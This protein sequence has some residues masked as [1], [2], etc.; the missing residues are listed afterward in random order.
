MPARADPENMKKKAWVKPHTFP[1]EHDKFY[2]S[3]YDHVPQEGE[4][5]FYMCLKCKK[6]YTHKSRDMILTKDLE[7]KDPKDRGIWGKCCGEFV[8]VRVGRFGDPVRNLSGWR[9]ARDRR[10]G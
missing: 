6:C 2:E 10:R 1:D 9:A 8:K 5:W 3:C 7:A 4:P